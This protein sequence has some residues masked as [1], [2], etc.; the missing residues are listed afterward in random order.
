MRGRGRSPSVASS[1]VRRGDG[2]RP[3][4]RVQCVEL[5]G[6]VIEVEVPGGVGAVCESVLVAVDAWPSAFTD[7]FNVPGGPVELPLGLVD[8]APGGAAGTAG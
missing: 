4:A 8:V 1:R 6:R 2:G 7:P 3:G 5:A